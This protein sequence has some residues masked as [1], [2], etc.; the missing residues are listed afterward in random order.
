MLGLLPQDSQLFEVLTRG[1]NLTNMIQYGVFD[2]DREKLILDQQKEARLG[3]AEIE[4]QA[5]VKF[6]DAFVRDQL[7]DENGNIKPVALLKPAATEINDTFEQLMRIRRNKPLNATNDNVLTQV[8]NA[9]LTIINE[10]IKQ[11]TVP[12]F[13][14]EF[15]T[16]GLA[17]GASPELFTLLQDVDVFKEDNT[18]IKTLDEYLKLSKEEVRRLKLSHSETQEPLSTQRLDNILGAGTVETIA[19][20]SLR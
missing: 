11:Q 15:F 13:I 17:E 2:F 10:N 1:A 3:R 7:F 12:G 19:T 6:D 20:Y 4:E 5:D 18:Q 9:R 16:L 14:K 8:L